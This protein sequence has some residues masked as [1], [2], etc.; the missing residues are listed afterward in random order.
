MS[1]RTRSLIG[2]L[3]AV[4]AVFL[5]AGTPVALATSPG[6]IIAIDP[7]DEPEAG[8]DSSSESQEPDD[9]REK[10][11]PPPEEPQPDCQVGGP[12]PLPAGA[13]E[14]SG[15]AVIL[16]GYPA[17]VYALPPAA[18][19]PC[20]TDLSLALAVESRRN[21]KPEGADATVEDR[22]VPRRTLEAGFRTEMP[23][24]PLVIPLSD[25]GEEWELKSVSCSCNGDGSST[26][27]VGAA[28]PAGPASAVLTAY[29]GPVLSLGPGVA[30][31]SVSCAGAAAA[32]PAT[33]IA[34]A[35]G[36]RADGHA[37][38]EA[39]MPRPVIGLPDPQGTKDGP[40]PPS[41]SSEPPAR[42]P[43][44]VSW[45]SDGT[46]SVG[47]PE[48][49]GAIVACAWTVEHV[50]GRVNVRTTTEPVGHEDDLAYRLT[51]A[52]F[53]EGRLPMRLEG[54]DA[55]D[56]R[57]A[58]R[59][60]W[61]LEAIDPGKGWQFESSSCSE[62]DTETTTTT[63]GS[64]VAVG[65]DAGDRVECT[66]EWSLLTPRAGRWTVVN[67]KG[68]AVCTAAAGGRKAGIT[69]PL[70]KEVG[71]GRIEHQRNG[72]RLYTRSAT[73]EGIPITLDRDPDDPTVYRGK[74]RLTLAGFTTVFSFTY[75]VRSERKIEGRLTATSKQGKTRCTISRPFS[76]T[77]A[78][79]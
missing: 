76:L 60:A 52:D 45:S 32:G 66:Y 34:V 29:P 12:R 43:A 5:L 39:A 9:A 17:P 16:A 7:V 56:E 74:E 41:E 63:K 4:L 57:L 72:D 26:A 68:K 37:P 1:D 10:D 61:T 42:R 47:D 19:P 79:S 55:G 18:Q 13:P 28:G 40:T 14:A 77:F 70:A 31:G 71:S 3:L 8:D 69:V 15:P 67:K 44:T 24:R 6:P 59:G 22:L 36:V 20:R 75:E 64:S 58:R 49:A 73:T 33:A 35:P 54:S 46:V 11:E 2:T 62:S 23:A 51:P 50:N 25:P 78:G 21:Q 53:S 38:R 27:A 48:R 65:M 30:A